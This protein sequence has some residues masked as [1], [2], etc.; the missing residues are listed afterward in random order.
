MNKTG[1]KVRKTKKSW[2][3]DK[4]DKTAGKKIEPRKERE[5]NE[6]KGKASGVGTTHRNQLQ[7]IGSEDA[8]P[9]EFKSNSE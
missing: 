6:K 1:G 3:W 4:Q 2:K 7:N 9:E 5:K 8:V